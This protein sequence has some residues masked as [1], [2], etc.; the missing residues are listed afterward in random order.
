MKQIYL[1]FSMLLLCLVV[2]LS[3]WGETKTVE[4]IAANQGYINGTQYKSAVVDANINLTF[5]NG[6][7]D[8]KY[9]DTGSGIRIYY[10][11]LVTVSANNGS[12]QKIVLT[13]SSASY[14]GS[15]EANSGDYKL[16]SNTGTWTG[17]ANS[18]V[19]KN[20]ASSGHARIQKITVTYE[21]SGSVLPEQYSYSIETIGKG[22]VEFKDESGKEV[23]SGDKVNKDTKISP[24]FTPAEGYEFTSW[25]YYTT[26][27]E[28]KSLDTNTPFTITKDVTFRVTFTQHQQ[29]GDDNP[30]DKDGVTYNFES[31]TQANDVTFEANDFTITL[32]K[33]TGST[34]PQWNG[35]SCEARVYAKG[36]VVVSSTQNIVKVVYDYAINA[37]KNGVLPT[38]DG[39]VGST[40]AGTWDAVSK[41]WSGS[42]KEITLTTSG[43]AGNLG[44]KSITVYFEKPDFSQKDI[45]FKAVNNDGYWATF[46]SESA[47]FFPED[48][49]VY[50]VYAQAGDP[51]AYLLTEGYETV[52]DNSL[53]E[54]S[55]VTVN[56]EEISGVYVPANTGVLIYSLEKEGTYYT[57]TKTVEDKNSQWN[58]LKASTV[59][60]EGNFKFY[61]LSYDND[62]KNLGFY[63]AEDNG[64][65]FTCNSGLAY[66]SVS[67]YM[68]IKSFVID[69]SAT[70][71]KAITNRM[72]V[73]YPIYNLAGQRVSANA[74]GILIQN[75]KKFFNK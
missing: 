29:G 45:S 51:T 22:T 60:M 57:T 44:F 63:W 66:L 56:G 5:G 39:V 9:Y 54:N 52:G 49:V 1:K 68:N 3:S 2:G 42:D 10:T 48:F 14:S 53:F 43:S 58:L 24:T 55:T 26:N 47:T 40:N 12:I 62:G 31:F 20:N 6:A 4:W 28:W 30:V 72:D 70:F 34:A 25:E 36:S 8:G 7:N 46:S 27:N 69:K 67:N 61:K 13:Y 71:I 73:N 15:F 11:G 35:N 23:K 18:V 59:P 21:I 65:A 33:N 50:A 41:T 38:V 75:G 74:K 32:Y 37:N 64:G 17:S 19:L 16:N